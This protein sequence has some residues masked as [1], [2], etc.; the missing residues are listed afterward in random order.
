MC[1]CGLRVSGVWVIGSPAM[2][3]GAPPKTPEWDER[4]KEAAGRVLLPAAQHGLFFLIPLSRH[5]AVEPADY[6]LKPLQTIS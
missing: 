1:D 4:A 2:E 3:M 5:P 6:G